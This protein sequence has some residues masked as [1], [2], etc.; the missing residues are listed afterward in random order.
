MNN[1]TDFHAWCFEQADLIRHA[2]YDELDIENLVEEIE[3]MGRQ[4]RDKL[5]SAL[6]ILFLHL[7]KYIYQPDYRSKSWL[8]SI[9]EQRVQ[10][11]W[12]LSDTP[13][14]KHSLDECVKRAYRKARYE[15]A[16]ETGLDVKTFSENYAFDIQ[17]ALTEGWL[18]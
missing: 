11:A 12:F 17:D 2:R 7:L 8:F 16:K 14:L 3:S 13:S 9:A 15:A 6:R 18:P 4:E 1:I 10:I 5:T